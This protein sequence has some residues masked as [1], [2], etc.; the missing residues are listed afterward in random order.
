[1]RSTSLKT[2]MML[3]G[4]DMFSG[5]NEGTVQY[6][7]SHR[8]KLRLSSSSKDVESE[9]AS[10]RLIIHIPAYAYNTGILYKFDVGVRVYEE[11]IYCL[12]TYWDL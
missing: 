5:I 11:Y 12:E 4:S 2:K 1:M 10:S 6:K 3:E 7:Q 9:G 8:H